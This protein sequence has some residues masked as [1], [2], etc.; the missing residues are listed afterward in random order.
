MMQERGAAESNVC[1]ARPGD[2]RRRLVHDRAKVCRY[3]RQVVKQ[4]NDLFLP[5]IRI[6]AQKLLGWEIED[7]VANLWSS[8]VQLLTSRIQIHPARCAVWER[9]SLTGDGA[10]MACYRS[11]AGRMNY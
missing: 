10:P 2:C 5:R 7:V 11:K 1:I 6:S 8:C 4:E 3:F 9:T